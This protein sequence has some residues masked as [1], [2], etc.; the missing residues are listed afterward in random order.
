MSQLLW[1]CEGCEARYAES[2]DVCPQCGSVAR[3]AD[4]EEESMPK[5]TVTGG[6]SNAAETAAAGDPVVAEAAEPAAAPPPEPEPKL[7]PKPA[8]KPGPAS[9]AAAASSDG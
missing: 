6:P 5:V 8:A 9:S 4:Y 2:L 3:H 1:V 7:E